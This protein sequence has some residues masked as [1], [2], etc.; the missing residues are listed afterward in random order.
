MRWVFVG[1]LVL[2]GCGMQLHPC[3][4]VPGSE[5]ELVLRD[6]TAGEGA[7]TLKERTPSPT[8]EA[9]RFEARGRTYDADL[10][11]PGD[12]VGAGMI[13]DPGASPYGRD[14]PR[15]IAF[16]KTL[17]RARFAVLVPDLPGPKQLRVKASDARDLADAFYFLAGRPDLS[18]GGRAGLGA[19]SYG[20][21]PAVMAALDP[22]IRSRMRFLL[23][24]GGY[25]NLGNVVTFFTTGYFRDDTVAGAAWKFQDPGQFGKWVF[26]KSYSDRLTDLNDA[27]ALRTM[28]DRKLADEKADIED[29]RT[30][31]GSEGRSV[32]A[33]LGNRDPEKVPG[34][35]AALPEPARVD[36]ADLNLKGRDLSEFRARPI[37]VHGYDD[38]I[39]PYTESVALAK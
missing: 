29:L 7:S 20:V 19:S 39:V 23:A 18:P 6:M 28:A 16:C 27:A 35:L 12:R 30:R 8:R 32:E 21:G 4:P 17:A 24:I 22:D 25:F 2:G 15:L 34:L 14:D 13:M 3:L 37:L 31:L 11:K 26:M 5:V 38:V 9:I 10:Y 36:L 33:L 1:T